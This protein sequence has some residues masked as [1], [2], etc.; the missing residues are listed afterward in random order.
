MNHQPLCLLRAPGLDDDAYRQLVAQATRPADWNRGVQWMLHGG[1]DRLQDSPDVAGLHMPWR[2]ARKH[3]SRPVDSRYLLAVS[4]HNREEIRHAVDLGADFI[5]L[6]PVKATGSHPG[7]EPME[8]AVFKDLVKQSPVVVY[9]LGGLN[10]EDEDTMIAC[11]AQGIAGIS[12][13]W[14]LADSENKQ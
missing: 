7:V 10:S 4:C 3:D 2:E 5:T 8:A 12:F 11:G 1:A 14:Q 13:W 6:G 9:G